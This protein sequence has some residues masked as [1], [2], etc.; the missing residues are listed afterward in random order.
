MLYE[1]KSHAIVGWQSTEKFGAQASKPPAEAP[2]PTTGKSSDLLEASGTNGSPPFEWRR[3]DLAPDS[4]SFSI[5]LVPRFGISL[6]G[7]RIAPVSDASMIEINLRPGCGFQMMPPG[8][9]EVKASTC[10]DLMP[11]TVLR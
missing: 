11:S 5:L 4:R 6:Q 1:D 3:P 10:S 2:M 7:L 8:H 9:T